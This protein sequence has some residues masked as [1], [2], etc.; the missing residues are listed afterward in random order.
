MVVGKCS[1][2]TKFYSFSEKC[3]F[4]KNEHKPKEARIGYF[5]KKSLRLSAFNWL[6]SF[7]VVI[8]AF[9]LTKKLQNV[10]PV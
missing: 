9:F 2:P 4:E 10:R 3:V 7:L 6:K 5:F 8:K 1:N